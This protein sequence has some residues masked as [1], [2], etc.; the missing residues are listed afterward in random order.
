MKKLNN[1]LILMI[2]VLLLTAC[3]PK[4]I[5]LGFKPEVG[6][7][8]QV[9]TT[10]DQDMTQNFGGQP[11]TISQHFEYGYTWHIT[12]ID[13]DGNAHVE[14][15]Y[16]HIATSQ[17]FGGQTLSYDSDTDEAPPPQLT[18]MDLMLGR[19]FSMVISARGKVLSID[20]LDEMYQDIV[21]A[22]DVPEDQKDTFYQA[23]E[24]SYGEAALS[25]QLSSL[26]VPYDETP[27]AVGHNWHIDQQVNGLIPV[28]I[29]TDYTISALDKETATIDVQST[30]SSDPENKTMLSG[31]QVAYDL[32]GTQTGSFTVR[33]ADGITTQATLQQHLEGSMMLS[34]G[35]AE[36]PVP[37]TIDTT[38]SYT[39]SKQ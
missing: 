2:A 24:D 21:D 33:I 38:L 34:Q 13:E 15:T 29:A 23:L 26:F 36:L 5:I 1:L 11:I 14:V 18:G 9:D 12:E 8:Y 25:E 37:L 10:M 3:T 27:A 35:D 20:G 19:G 28:N 31:Y 32:S 17:S 7:T 30:L 22:S 6:A 39:M 4:E 16:N